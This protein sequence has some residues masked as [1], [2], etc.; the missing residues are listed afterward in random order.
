M[1]KG[2]KTGGRSKGTPN[3]LT[4]ETKELLHSVVNSEIKNLPDRLNELDTKDRLNLIAKFLPYILPKETELIEDKDIQVPDIYF[5]VIDKNGEPLSNEFKKLS[6]GKGD[7][8]R[9]EN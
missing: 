8:D 2:F 9:G 3:K 6:Y 7:E 4:S 5:S 1:A